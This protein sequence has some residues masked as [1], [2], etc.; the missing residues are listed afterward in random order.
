MSAHRRVY[1]AAI[2]GLQ[3]DFVVDDG[4]PLEERLQ[5]RR[6]LLRVLVDVQHLCADESLARVAEPLHR[7]ADF[8][9]DALVIGLAEDVLHALE[10]AAILGLALPQR[11]LRPL[12]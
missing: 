10:Y 8:D 1:D 5:E 6:P 2:S 4:S 3:M 11:L 7:R 9:D 12:A